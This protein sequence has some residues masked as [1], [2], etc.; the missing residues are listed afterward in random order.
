MKCLSET[1]KWNSSILYESSQRKCVRERKRERE[2]DFREE[3]RAHTKST[4]AWNIS[5][6]MYP[7][8][9]KHL[10]FVFFYHATHMYLM[11][12]YIYIYISNTLDFLLY[13]I[14]HIAIYSENWFCVDW[15]PMRV[16]L[17]LPLSVYIACF[18]SLFRS[19]SLRFSMFLFVYKICLEAAV[20]RMNPVCPHH[21][22][23]KKE[24]AQFTSM[25]EPK[26]LTSYLHLD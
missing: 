13:V 9:W 17:S 16:S 4:N 26:S 20:G 3:H 11:N 19:F 6:M 22:L 7:L 8:N 23:K 18:F 10:V 14:Y 2:G 24:N 5:A 12:T 25:S 21:Q 15:T 1:P